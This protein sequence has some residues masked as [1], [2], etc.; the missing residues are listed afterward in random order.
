MNDVL[1]FLEIP[2]AGDAVRKARRKEPAGLGR[3][4]PIFL[5]SRY[6][7]LYQMALYLIFPSP[8]QGNDSLNLSSLPRPFVVPTSFQFAAL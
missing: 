4:D 7:A 5:Y 2:G 6:T 1:R 8:D 3:A